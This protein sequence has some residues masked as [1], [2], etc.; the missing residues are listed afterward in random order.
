MIRKLDEQRKQMAEIIHRAAALS[1]SLISDA[2]AFVP[3]DHEVAAS[4]SSCIEANQLLQSKLNQVES[5]M[6][7]SQERI[8]QLEAQLEV[9]REEIS[10]FD[11][12]RQ[13]LK[14]MT[15]HEVSTIYSQQIQQLQQ[16]IYELQ[17][18][19][20]DHR[21]KE[22]LEATLQESHLQC[23]RLVAEVDIA[24]KTVESLQ[25]Q[26]ISSEV[27]SLKD[28]RRCVDLQSALD[29]SDQKCE[30]LQRRNVAMQ[31]E[32]THEQETIGSLEK[33]VKALRIR[34]EI[35]SA[36]EEEVDRF[37]QTIQRQRESMQ[38]IIDDLRQQLR[39]R[40][41]AIKDAE[42]DIQS[43]RDKV[44]EQY[45][46]LET[47]RSRCEELVMQSEHRESIEAELRAKL[48][49]LED[50]L[51]ALSAKAAI[52]ANTLHSVD[53]ASTAANTV[54]D[55]V[56]E[57]NYLTASQ[58]VSDM[59]VEMIQLQVHYFTACLLIIV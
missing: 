36:L 25:Q 23:Q 13:E 50:Q 17:I 12:K 20:E 44:K 52:K 24:R 45:S 58:T 53:D 46:T 39:E 14:D 4:A 37:K 57:V 8:Q 34:V 27:S 5:E 16:T 35:I 28:R 30:D 19:H 3:T 51:Q 2:P 26:I 55:K 11:A 9:Y 6:N 56:K 42:F 7:L 59:Q 21:N 38:L 43:L 41:E 31:A 54:L 1:P 29:A 47:Y 22:I 15:R 33:E 40:D 18:R 10:S 32:L 49:Q 48:N